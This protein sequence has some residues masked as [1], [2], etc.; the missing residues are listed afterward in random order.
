MNLPDD[1]PLPMMTN[2]PQ[3]CVGD[4]SWASVIAKGLVRKSTGNDVVNN[5]SFLSNKIPVVDQ[6]NSKNSIVVDESSL[7][8]E[9]TTTRLSCLLRLLF[10]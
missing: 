1:I 4:H 9:V 5:K 8:T 10:K 7:R 3:E 2:G 6:D